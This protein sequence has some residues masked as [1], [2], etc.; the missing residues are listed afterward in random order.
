MDL[1]LDFTWHKDMRGYRL[2]P[3]KFPRL[4]PGQSIL[5][6]KL[7]DIQPARI[8]RNGGALQSYRPLEMVSRLHN[9][10]ISLAKTE[11]GVLRFVETFG[12]LTHEGL[13]GKGDVVQY[14]IDQADDMMKVRRGGIEGRL[15]H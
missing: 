1:T 13:R 15:F 10:F 3:A 11:S 5:D 12:P 14:A 8:V 4:R 9:Q 6:A 2:V 7:A